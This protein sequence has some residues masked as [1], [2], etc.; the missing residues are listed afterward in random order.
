VDDY[1]N[2]ENI[3]R[4]DGP[5]LNKFMNRQASLLELSN[6][7]DMAKENLKIPVDRFESHK[8]SLPQI[9]T[10]REIHDEYAVKNSDVF[11][12]N[13]LPH[14]H[15]SNINIHKSVNAKGG[16]SRDHSNVNL[17]YANNLKVG[18]R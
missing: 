11:R 18:S 3:Q 16:A 2:Q 8:L 5:T 10:G 1:L 13:N 14:K 7:K 15:K 4:N 12:N 9:I 6:T 17:K